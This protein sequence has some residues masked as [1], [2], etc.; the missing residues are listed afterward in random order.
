MSFM[1][2]FYFFILALG[3]ATSVHAQ[4]ISVSEAAFGD[5]ISEFVVPVSKVFVHSADLSSQVIFVGGVDT[6]QTT[7]TYGNPAGQAIAK[8]WHDFIGFTPDTASDSDALGW[9]SVNHE[10][11]LRDSLIGDGGGMTVFK[12]AK[13][14]DGSLTVLDQTLSDGRTG[15]F[16]N[17]DFVNTVGSTGMNCGG[18]SAANGRIWTAE[19]WFR[20]SNSD[21]DDRDTSDFIIGQGTVNGLAAPNGFPG[22]NGAQIKKF[23]NY[24]YMVEIDPKEA[25]AVRKQYNWGRQPFE[26]GVVLEDSIAFLGGDATPG[27]FTR[28]LADTAGSF[29]NGRTFFY[30]H[31]AGS[32][33]EGVWVEVDMSSIDTVLN[34][35]S[36]ALSQGATMFN[37]IEWVAHNPLNG[38]VYFTETGRD[39]PGSRF[40]GGKEAGGILAPH[41]ITRATEQGTVPDSADYWDYYG[42]V[43]EYNPSTGEMNVYI[44]GGPLYDQGIGIQE[45]DTKRNL[46]NPDGLNFF[47]SEDGTK[48]YMI[49][50]EDLNG[51]SWG[52]MPLG[53]SNRT[54]ELWLL[55][56]DVVN[57]TVDDLTRIGAVPIGAEVTGAI[58]LDGNTILV[59]S[60]HPDA[61]INEFPFNNSLTIALSGFGE[62]I[63]TDIV[64]L[65]DAE[66]NISVYPNPVSQNLF[67]SETMKSVTVFTID[68]KQISHKERANSVNF[69]TWT[70]GVYVVRLVDQ[71]GNVYSSKVIKE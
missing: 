45:F 26:G 54:C 18:I 68:G 34:F 12:V 41:H 59:N 38:N 69:Q 46:S 63:S 13:E 67:F 61:N 53:V 66:S 24:N 5:S 48:S 50:N 2:K 49:I 20:G 36:V 11:I 70:Q 7:A 37:R 55:D 28:F 30:K 40:V 6:V 71:E 47:V 60:Q 23:E 17:V 39:N 43:M 1:R 14:G 44:E 42:R 19:E 29:L 52:R 31:D 10:M 22:Y 25:V 56:M 8:Q 21:I 35:P 3:F 4:E 32:G 51:T 9:V 33:A 15:K 64:E 16:F 57:P 65:I 62:D 27:L 58:Q